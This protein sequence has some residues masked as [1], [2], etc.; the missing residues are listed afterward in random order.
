VERHRW[1]GEGILEDIIVC[2]YNV[3]PARCIMALS[4]GTEFADLFE[5]KEG[6]AGSG[7]RK[8]TPAVGRPPSRVSGPRPYPAHGEWAVQ[9]ALV[10]V[11]DGREAS[12]PL[13]DLL[14]LAR[15][16]RKP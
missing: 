12:P 1:V 5:G 13:D 11:V 4:V 3:E 8:D 14:E 16:T 9:V 7:S 6:R 2:N 15:L 10:P